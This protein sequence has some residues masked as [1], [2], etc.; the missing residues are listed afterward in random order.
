MTPGCR[1]PAGS[2]GV[3]L[4][5]AMCGGA[6]A[7][8]ASA[9]AELAEPYQDRVLVD[10]PPD[11]PSADR[12]TAHNP[13]GWPRMVRLES[14]WRKTAPVEQPRS[15]QNPYLYGLL[16]T[17]NLGAISIDGEI[18][19]GQGLGSLTLRQSDM[20]LANGWWANH[21]A[22]FVYTTGVPLSRKPSRVYVPSALIRGVRGEW[23]QPGQV[24]LAQASIGE[25]GRIDTLG[26]NEFRGTG[27]GRVAV[28]L[29]WD[30][31]VASA[32]TRAT[33]AAA[34]QMESEHAGSMT[35]THLAS[36]QK[37]NPRINTDS[38][39]MAARHE[40]PDNRIQVNAL[41]SLGNAERTSTQGL[42]LDSSWGGDRQPQSAGLYWLEPGLNW[43]GLPM[44]NDLAGVYVRRAWRAREWSAEG[45]MDWLRSIEQPQRQ[46]Y[47][48]TGAA[49]WRL[50][51]F[52]QIGAG[53]SVR[54]YAGA[55]WSSFLDWRWKNPWGLG[56]VRWDQ[57]KVEAQSREQQLT[58]D[59]DWDVTRGWGLM[60]SFSLARVDQ[61]THLGAG[62]NL[63]MPLSSYASARASLNSGLN[64]TSGQH[65][66]LALGLN[67]RVMRDWSLDAQ[68]T[69]YSGKMPMFSLDPLAP[70]LTPLKLNNWS[71][72]VVLR[73]E[74]QAGSTVAPLGGRLR[75]GGGRIKGTVYMDANRNGRR[76]ADEQG[77]E[78]VPVYLD[79]RYMVRTDAQG[80]YEFSLV[81]A[82]THIVSIRN[83]SLPLPWGIVGDGQA[84]VNVVLREG[85]TVD[86]P[87]QPTE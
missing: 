64:G 29:Q 79:N 78:G 51:K 42:W 44:A 17:P 67:W 62:L 12:G 41:R 73:F 76:D 74:W 80:Q 70:P 66:N 71:L 21:E 28:G 53:L 2:L 52:H 22:G 40:A 54:R 77:A 38:V 87:I 19:P 61:E 9:Q 84:R 6:K 3:A 48:A 85:L 55:G 36:D 11:T 37:T 81:A 46:G 5:M 31:L 20:P 26:N 43:A 16:E 27:S 23:T 34:V 7:Q 82:G 86:F 32:S 49:R 47:Y 60:T 14:R 25:P 10:L 72:Y 58:F 56:G 33:W 75:E 30:P 1:R 57:S 35:P 13:A 63:A 24:F 8:P 15:Q 39:F 65:L 83:E 4:A 18:G 59:Q 45:S 69:R 68:Y 50:N